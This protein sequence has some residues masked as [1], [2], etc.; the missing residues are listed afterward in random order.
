[1]SKS[2]RKQTFSVVVSRQYLEPAASSIPTTVA[3]GSLAMFGSSAV[4]ASAPAVMTAGVL[5][6][7][8]M[9]KSEYGISKR[10]GAA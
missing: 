8:D 4:S 5:Q 3:H 2:G 10:I 1:M 7:D 6:T 9:A